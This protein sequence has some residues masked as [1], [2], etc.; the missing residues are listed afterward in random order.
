MRR[1]PLVLGRA[2]PPSTVPPVNRVK[3]VVSAMGA[4]YL[5]GTFPTADLVARRAAGGGVDLRATGSGNPGSA[6]VLNV[7]GAKAGASVLVGDIGKGAAACAIGALVAGPVG[8]HLAGTSS[9]IGHCYPVWNGFQ[10]GKGVA[11]SVGQCLATFPAYFPIDVAVAVVTASNPTWKQRAFATTVA[12]CACWFVGG[13]V[14]WARGK[15]NLWGPRPSV[16]L[17]IA[18]ALTSAVIIHRFAAARPPSGDAP[19]GA[20]PVTI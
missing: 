3:R 1:T 9:V 5:V 6:N 20:E 14:W 15:R 17:P 2:R 8:A 16:M 11:T 12:S 18:S 10:G 13:V 19:V 7:L 4:G